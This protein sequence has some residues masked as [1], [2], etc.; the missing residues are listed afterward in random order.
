[1]YNVGFKYVVVNQSLNFTIFLIN[2]YDFQ[3]P[4]KVT[5]GKS[6]R[7][8]FKSKVLYV[9]SVYFWARS[10]SLEMTKSK[11]ITAIERPTSF[12]LSHRLQ[13]TANPTLGPR[14]RSTFLTAEYAEGKSC[15]CIKTIKNTILC[16]RCRIIFSI[17]NSQWTIC[18]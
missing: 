16:S 2:N 3:I 15:S 8:D 5:K 9:P 6:T 7:D 12:D 1:M 10:F 11:N 18:L 4:V 17:L 14:W 13:Q